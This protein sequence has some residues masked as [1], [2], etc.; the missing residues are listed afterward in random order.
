MPC[1]KRK[2]VSAPVHSGPVSRISATFDSLRSQEEKALVVFVTGGDPPI[3][4]LPEILRTLEAG[5]ADLIEV[6]LPFSDPIAD[7]PTIQ[8]SSQRALDRNVKVH[9]IF[10]AVRRS[11]VSAPIVYMG[12]VNTAMRAGFEQF[13]DDAASSGASGVLLSDLTPDEAGTWREAARSGGLDTIFLIAPTSTEARVQLAC[14]AASG[15]V[16]CVSRT[17]VTGAGHEV[18]GEVAQTVA[19]LRRHTRLPICVGLGISNP[20]QVRM[21][22]Q[23]ADGAVVGSHLVALL[24]S[25]WDEGRGAAALRQDIAALKAATRS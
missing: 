25:S 20:E 19:R 2:V 21:V 4:Q 6:G 16:Y 10:D 24:H 1:S 17:G 12:Y 18:P 3:E 7:G 22:C 11:D 9:D 15:F 14:D 8:A 23:V 13:C 5:G